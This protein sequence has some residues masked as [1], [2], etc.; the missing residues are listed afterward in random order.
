M[1]IS[2]VYYGKKHMRA[3]ENRALKGI[4]RPYT[5]YLKLE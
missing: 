2:L 4:F 1:A 5:P 3:L